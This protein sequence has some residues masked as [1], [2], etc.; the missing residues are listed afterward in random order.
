MKFLLILALCIAFLT[1][2]Y[3]QEREVLI[4]SRITVKSQSEMMQVMRLGLDLLEYRDGDDLV[5]YTTPEKLDA[6]REAGWKV[7]IDDNLTAE[8]P[9]AVSPET[10]MG[11]YRSV[12]ETYAFLNQMAGTYPNLAQVFTYGQSWAKTQNAANGYNLT[13]IK[14]TNNQTTGNKPIFFLQAG[15]HARELVPPEMATRFIEYLLSNYGK[16]ADATWLLDEHQIIVIPIINPDGRKIAETGQLKRKNIN[17][18]TGGCSQLSAGIDLNRNY[19]FHWGIVNMPTDP[20]CGDTWPGLTAASEPETQ[21]EQALILSLFPDQRLPDRNSPAPLDATGVFLDMHSTSNLV[22][23]PWGED[24]LPPPNLQLRTIARKTASY[25]GYNPIQTIDLYP[26]S[27]TAQ[28]WAYGEL[29]IAGFGMETGL[30]SGNCGGFMPPY[31]C[32][33]GGANGNFWLLNRPVLLYF[34]KIA[35]TPYMTGEGPT[36]ETLTIARTGIGAFT[37]RAQVNDV[38][39]GNQNISAAEIYV[40][41]PPWRGGVP[42]TMTPEDGSFNSPVEFALA[43]VTLSPGRHIIFARGRDLAGNWGAIKAVFTPQ[44][45]VNADFDGDRRTDVSVFRPADTVWYVSTSGN[46]GF[47][48]SQFGIPTDKLVPQDY[49][50][51]GKTDLAVYRNGLW[52]ILRSGNGTYAVFSFGLANDI[53]VP[54]DYDGDD[55]ADLAVYR[56]GIWYLL[57]SFDNSFSAVSFGL[58]GDRP[59]IG[60]YDGD[61]KSDLA[62]FRPGDGNWYL[63]QSSLGFTSINWGISSDKPVQ[64]DYDGDGKT[65]LAVYRDGM[66]Y[67]KRSRDG[68]SVFPFGL[69]SDIPAAGDYDGDGK[70]DAAVYRS[71]VWYM[72]QSTGGFRA[73]SF[74]LA[75]DKPIPAAY[76]PQ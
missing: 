76:F 15:I 51:D 34:A 6:L 55:R 37:L 62:V 41:T 3:G 33:D 27:G 31:S 48:A 8:L 61:G 67:L 25:N 56:D 42:I 4:V 69:S 11:G 20:P 65:D 19:A 9:L 73:Q 1:P 24:N 35:R 29:G 13:A 26:T 36:A 50:G 46:N 68:N 43:N 47:S 32:L 54:A 16:D 40:D 21:A 28:D 30:G 66:W 64:G 74:G 75:S 12:E 7:R 18:I 39:N 59:V 2:L 71:G 5:F 44:K 17:N 45:A 63:L 14:L 52:H 70:A 57:K 49:D 72:L 60:D 53:P 58:T 23:Y 22:L 38:N 10:F